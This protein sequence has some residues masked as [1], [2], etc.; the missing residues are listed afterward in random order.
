MMNR[1]KKIILCIVLLF[2]AVLLCFAVYE[3][4]G[5]LSKIPGIEDLWPLALCMQ[6]A[7]LLLPFAALLLRNKRGTAGKI[8]IGIEIAAICL[9]LAGIML[10]RACNLAE[11]AAFSASVG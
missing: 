5:W 9:G 7:W 3:G 2:L 10:G 6:A 8:R 11:L 1:M 4:A